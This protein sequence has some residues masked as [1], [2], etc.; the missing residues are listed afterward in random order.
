MEEG[1]A[2]GFIVDGEPRLMG[3]GGPGGQPRGAQTA[4]LAE[5][6][7]KLSQLSSDLDISPERAAAILFYATEH[8]LE[9]WAEL[10]EFFSGETAALITE[11][12][13]ATADDESS[14]GHE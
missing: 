11:A 6:L 14:G 5:L 3:S 12:M 7:E 1:M 4:E 13:E 2:L 10:L 8:Q 9:R